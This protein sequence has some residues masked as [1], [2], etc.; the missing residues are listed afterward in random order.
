MAIVDLV[1]GLFGQCL[2]GGRPAWWAARLSVRALGLLT[3]SLLLIAGSSGLP[4]LSLHH[5]FPDYWPIRSDPLAPADR[6]MLIRV[7]LAGL[8]EIPAGQLAQER[9]GRPIVKEVGAQLRDDHL[10]LDRQ[11]RSVAGELGVALPDQPNAQQ[12]EWLAELSSK[13]GEEFDKAFTWLLRAAH[14]GVFATVAAVRASTTNDVVRQFAETAVNIV[15]KHMR[16]LESTDMVDYA[17]L[18]PPPHPPLPRVAFSKRAL[19][20]V[21]FVW[22]V[23]AVAVLAGILATARIIRPR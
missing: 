19:P 16:L 23:L 14:G 21:L 13:S 12:R 10:E 22:I 8:W 15:M 6:D 5:N 7:R 2:A 3:S 1:A 4:A 18:T 11:V 17:S 9:A 20:D